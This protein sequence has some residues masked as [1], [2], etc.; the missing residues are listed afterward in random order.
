LAK[1]DHLSVSDERIKLEK[2]RTLELQ[3]DATYAA[4]ISGKDPSSAELAALAA[5]DHLSPDEERLKTINDRLSS[6]IANYDERH[7]PQFTDNDYAAYAKLNEIKDIK[8]AK[9]QIAFSVQYNIATFISDRIDHNYY[10]NRTPEF[11]STEYEAW[12]AKYKVTPADAK[13][14]IE[15]QLEL[16]KASKMVTDQLDSGL[17]PDPEVLSHAAKLRGQTP[18]QFRVENIELRIATLQPDSPTLVFTAGDYAAE[19]KV[20]PELSIEQVHALL[21]QEVKDK[22]MSFLQEPTTPSNQQGENNP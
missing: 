12:A 3:N 4:L 8:N 21:D 9:E 6:I 17:E 7:P 18:E 5:R 14:Q 15:K 13:T 1:A 20:H 10:V 11:T 19:A 2:E 22:K 16:A